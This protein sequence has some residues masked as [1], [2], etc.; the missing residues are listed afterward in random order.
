MRELTLMWS[1]EI[2]SQKSLSFIHENALRRVSKSVR[3]FFFLFSLVSLHIKPESIPEHDFIS[4]SKQEPKS[5][6][7]FSEKLREGLFLR[8]F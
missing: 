1:D 2:S 6:H 3:A 4:D 7:R 8:E 5:S